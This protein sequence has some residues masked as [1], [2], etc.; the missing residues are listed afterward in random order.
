MTKLEIPGDPGETQ[1]QADRLGKMASGY[2]EAAD[3]IRN[4]SDDWQGAA[5]EAARRRIGPELRDRVAAVSEACQLANTA[6]AG[7]APVLQRAQQRA[8]EIQ[9]RLEELDQAREQAA[10]RHQQATAQFTANPGQTPDPGPWQDPTAAERDQLLEEFGQLKAEVKEAAQRA[11]G[12]LRRATGQLPD[13]PNWLAQRWAEAKNIVSGGL[14]MLGDSAKAFGGVALGTLEGAAALGKFLITPSQWDDAAATVVQ[15]AEW[16]FSDPVGN[17]KALPGMIG[18]AM[19]DSFRKDP[20][21][22]TAGAITSVIPVG[23]LAKGGATVAGKAAGGLGKLGRVVDD[24]PTPHPHT[25]HPH[26]KPGEFGSGT[27]SAEY[28]ERMAERFDNPPEPKPEPDPKPDPSPEPGH[29]R[30]DQQGAGWDDGPDSWLE[31]PNP[32]AQSSQWNDPFPETDTP[33]SEQLVPQRDPGPD[34]QRINQEVAAAQRDLDQAI[35]NLEKERAENPNFEQV[36]PFLENDVERARA[37]YGELRQ[38]QEAML[39]QAGGTR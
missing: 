24:V 38:Q 25:P 35:A 12:Q 32:N 34:I 36:R 20:L 1:R 14:A 31:D 16:F 28:Y 33:N 2:G 18:S 9:Q 3:A 17:T 7:Y 19:A 26:P 23:G 21:G 5:A 8:R 39:R 15:G 22:F 13:P 29:T 11:A 10:A 30:G 37:R 27:P 4:I 6:L